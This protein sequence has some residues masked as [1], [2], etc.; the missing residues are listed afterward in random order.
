VG[1]ETLELGS[2]VASVLGL[3]VAGASVAGASVGSPSPEPLQDANTASVMINAINK[4]IILMF[5]IAFSFLFL[6]S[7]IKI[8]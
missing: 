3:S 4:A 2:S 1:V 6:I 8:S 5:F 7:L